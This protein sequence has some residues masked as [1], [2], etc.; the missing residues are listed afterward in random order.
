LPQP[1]TVKEITAELLAR[2]GEWSGIPPFTIPPQHVVPL[3]DVFRPAVA[4]EY[5]ASV[6][7]EVVARI[8]VLA[9]DGRRTIVVVPFVGKTQLH[10]TVDGV[11]CMRGGRYDPIVVVPEDIRHAGLAAES[12]LLAELLTAIHAEGAA[13]TT[14]TPSEVFAD[15]KRSAGRLPPLERLPVSRPRGG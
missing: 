3:L 2:T 15:L 10:F 13:G 11:R 1:A 14:T 7:S 12:I 4:Y 8:T 9:T 6:D 5:P